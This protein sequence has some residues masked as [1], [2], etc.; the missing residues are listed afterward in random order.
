MKTVSVASNGGRSIAP[1]GIVTIPRLN[2][3]TAQLTLIGEAPVIVHNWSEKAEKQMLDKQKGEASAGKKAKDP[4]EEFYGSLYLTPEGEYGIPAVNFKAAAV[5]AAPDVELAMTEMRRAFHVVGEILKI[6]APPLAKKFFTEYDNQYQAKLTKAHKLGASMRRDFVRLASGVADIRF[7]AVFPIWSVNLEI[8][9]NESVISL[10]Q[11][12][13]LFQAAGFGCGVC[14]WRP[15]S[16]K[17]KSG[18]YGTWKVKT[19]E[20]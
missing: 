9:Y 4:V 2:I 11:L 1:A 19:D 18:S 5:S 15:S 12:L 7:R 10:P 3:K 16:P 14:E 20:S 6:E 8:R 13:N 17:V